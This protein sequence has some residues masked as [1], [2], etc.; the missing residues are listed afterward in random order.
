MD[1]F[2][3]HESVDGRAHGTKGRERARDVTITGEGD[4]ASIAEVLRQTGRRA[5]EFDLRGLVRLFWR[6]HHGQ[7]SFRR[8][9]D[10]GHHFHAADG[11]LTS[12]RFAREHDRVSQFQDSVR[13]VRHFGTGR[14]GVLNHRLQHV[15]RDDDRFAGGDGHGDSLTLDER[16]GL[17]RDFNPKVTAR[18]H[19]GIGGAEN[20]PEVFDGGL[21]F[22]LRDDVG[23]GVMLEQQGTEGVDVRGF[24]HERQGVEIDADFAADGHVGPV[25]IGQGREVDFDPWK[26]DVAA[27]A[28]GARLFDF[29]T[30][31]VGLLFEHAQLDQAVVDEDDAADRHRADHLRVVGRDNEDFALGLGLGGASDVDQLAGGQLGGFRPC[32]GPDFGAFDVHHDRQLLADLLADFTHPGDGGPDPGVVGVGHIQADH[33]GAGFDNRL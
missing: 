16:Q 28:E 25:L 22:D 26:V 1:G 8:G 5:E 19:E 29:A 9:G 21:V 14:D 3:F 12:R 33:I 30:Q 18:H 23:L 31:A 24:A 15:R 13:D 10:T 20:I 32:T 17:V 6:E 27:A 4:D 2:L 7:F 11:V